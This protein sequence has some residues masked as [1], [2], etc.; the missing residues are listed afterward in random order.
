MDR[1][2]HARP[3]PARIHHTP[4]RSLLALLAL[5]GMLTAP[6]VV[7]H[8]SGTHNSAPAPLT[9]ASS[10]GGTNPN[11]PPWCLTEDD[12][13]QQTYVGSLNGSYAASARLCGLVTDVFAGMWWDAGGIGLESDVYVVG[14]L[15]DLAIVAP[16]GTAH[17][18]VFMGQT[19]VKHVTT[20]HYAVCYVPPFSLT[21]NTGGTPL[22]GGTWSLALSGSLS[23]AT[24]YVNAQMTD[25]PYQQAHCPASEQNLAP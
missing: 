4:R 6:A 23:S 3:E 7:A 25:V 19:T 12:W 2:T 18:A 24:W 10:S 5:A 1:S 21:S 15:G 20:S 8:A 22:P 11:A 14:Q 17:H 9:L 13:T 16:D